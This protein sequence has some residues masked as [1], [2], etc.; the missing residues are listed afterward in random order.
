[1]S[2]RPKSYRWIGIP[3]VGLAL[4]LALGSPPA[5][6]TDP[7]AQ[8]L[9]RLLETSSEFRVRTQ[10][11]LNLGRTD[12]GAEVIQA[13][14]RALSDD[15]AAVRAAAATSLGAVGDASAIAALQRLSGD[16]D[17]AVRTAAASAV[18][19]IQGRVPGPGSTPPSGGGT[20]PPSGGGTPPAAG[21]ARYYVGVG[22]PGTRADRITPELLRHARSVLVAQIGSVGGAVVAPEGETT[23]AAAAVI[24]QRR[25]AGV[26]I[27]CS[28]VSADATANGTRVAVS[29]IVGTY[30]GRDMRAILNGAATVPGAAGAEAD[31]AAIEGAIRGA[32]RNLPQA[33]TQAAGR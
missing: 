12:G 31:R 5:L 18:R 3:A 13:L 25:L 23:S 26:Y 6:A 1:M 21:S 10:A 17:A 16:R 33:M 4:A 28:I 2:H 7:R 20:P 27:D 30:P 11:A 29:V 24:Q 15:N 14:I 9:I 32:L 8:T 22:M 19:Q